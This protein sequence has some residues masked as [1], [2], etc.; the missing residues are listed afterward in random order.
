MRD[1]FNLT[2]S[3]LFFTFP[4]NIVKT[5]MGKKTLSRTVLMPGI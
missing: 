4:V 2:K 5:M 1:I 3:A